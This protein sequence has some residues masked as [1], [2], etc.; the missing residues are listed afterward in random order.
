MTALAFWNAAKLAVACRWALTTVPSPRAMWCAISRKLSP[1][2]RRPITS[3]RSTNFRGLPMRFYREFRRRKLGS[4]M[5]P[6]PPW[7]R[8]SV[9]GGFSACVDIGE[10]RIVHGYE[11]SMGSGFG[12]SRF[13]PVMFDFGSTGVRGVVSLGKNTPR[14]I[15]FWTYSGLAHLHG[16]GLPSISTA[17]WPCV[18]EPQC[19]HW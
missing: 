12:K 15:S 7:G 18:R 19:G 11:A 16:T 2:H 4:S 5:G 1:A 13:H 8:A 14:S 10:I 9:V 3:T 17:P 6:P